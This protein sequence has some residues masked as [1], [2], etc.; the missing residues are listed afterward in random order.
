MLPGGCGINLVATSVLVQGFDLLRVDS[1]LP[2]IVPNHQK[3]KLPRRD[4]STKNLVEKS[5]AIV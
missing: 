4:F 3:P 1:Y 2:S 5:I